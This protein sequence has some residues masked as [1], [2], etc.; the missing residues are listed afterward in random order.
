MEEKFNLWAVASSSSI[1]LESQSSKSHLHYPKKIIVLQANDREHSPGLSVNHL[2]V[3]PSD[4]IRQVLTAT[5]TVTTVKHVSFPRQSLPGAAP[6]PWEQPMRSQFRYC[7]RT[8]NL[9]CA[10]PNNYLMWSAPIIWQIFLFP[11]VGLEIS[12][13]AWNR[14]GRREYSK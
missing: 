9:Y 12:T 11:P 10:R 6:C 3:T 13:H 1:P 2:C 14:K 8:F 4:S 7:W 5:K